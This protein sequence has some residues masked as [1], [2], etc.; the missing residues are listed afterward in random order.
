MGQLLGCFQANFHCQTHTHTHTHTQSQSKS[1]M[2]RTFETSKLPNS[3][4]RAR[5]HHAVVER[6]VVARVTHDTILAAS[7]DDR[8]PDTCHV[9]LWLGIESFLAFLL[10]AFA[11]N[12]GKTIS[13]ES[14][15][16][17]D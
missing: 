3:T 4:P 7:W 15:P 13:Q 16:S 2:W 6:H 9:I 14:G 10:S 11:D 17:I 5:V 12:S 1:L 8:A